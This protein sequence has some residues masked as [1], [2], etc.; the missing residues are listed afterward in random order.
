M[1]QC[2]TGA[3]GA[4]VDVC[5][6]CG[7]EHIQN[8]SCRNR[9]CPTCQ[10]LSQEQWI[11]A[12]SARML[13]VRHFHV[14]FALPAQLRPL[15]R[16]CSTEID[17]ALFS[18]ASATLADLADTHLGGRLGVTMV[19]HTWTRDLQ[20][21]PH[22]HAIVTAG[23]Y[24]SQA[25]RWVGSRPKY[26]F[27]V[28]VMGALLRGKMIAALR[29]LDRS[30]VFAGVRT[31]AGPDAFDDLMATLAATDWVVYA[32]QTFRRAE[33]VLAYLGRYTHR[34]A[35]ANSRRV[36][37]N[38][39]AVTFRTKDGNA[40]TLSP[41][42]FLRRFIQHV[43]PLGFHK[44][45]HYG[46]YSS[47][48]VRPGNLFDC[49]RDAL[50]PTDVSPASDETNACSSAQLLLRLTGR[51]ITRCPHCGGPLHRVVIRLPTERAPPFL[52]RAA[53]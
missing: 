3:L 28:K 16:A 12:R 38:D 22:V 5:F 53:A 34:V 45:R 27:A 48:R 21:H 25:S 42:A 39:H 35:I 6:A 2:R 29:G 26:L 24:D 49:A 14:V 47:A 4:H 8:N 51:D 19:L 1:E 9:H 41:V 17:T 15:A 46:L 20:F 43:L 33:H 18:A 31:L 50:A 32:K 36:K 30:G 11:A 52:G 7:Y 37:V 44:I 23:G 40:V 13:P 10:G